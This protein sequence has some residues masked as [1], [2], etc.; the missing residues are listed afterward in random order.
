MGVAVLVDAMLG[1]MLVP[2]FG[3]FAVSEAVAT[4][5]CGSFRM[6]VDPTV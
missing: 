4:T 2:S 1:A 5:C 6:I 3:S